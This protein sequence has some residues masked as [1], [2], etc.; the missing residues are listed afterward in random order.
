MRIKKQV[1]AKWRE[2]LIFHKGGVGRRTYIPEPVN[3]PQAELPE[4][5]IRKSELNLP[6]VSELELVRHVI[7]LSQMSYAVDTGTYPLGSCTMK[8]N[9]KVNER[10]A[11]F[12][13]FLLMHPDAPESIQ[14]GSLE[15][16]YRLQEALKKITGFSNFSVQPAGGAQGEYTGALMMTAYFTEKQDFGRKKILIPDSA[17]GTNPATATMA[18]FQAVQIP[19]NEQGTVDINALRETLDASVAGIMLT[20]PNTLGIFETEILEINRMIHSVGALSYMDGA[21]FNGIMG[22]AKP[23]EMGF[24]IMHLNLHK[25]FTGP[26]GGG[27]PGSGPVGVIPMLEKFLPTPL[28]NYDEKKDEYFWDTTHLETSIG[29]VHGY[30]GNFGINL[31]A[32]AYIYRNGGEGLRAVCLSAVLNA[33]YL[34]HKIKSVK[35]LNVPKLQ[36]LQPCK[37]E[38]V[39]SAKTLVKDT[40]ISALDI[41]KAML[42]YGIHSPTIYFPLIIKEAL[43]IEPTESETYQELNRL[44]KIIKQICEDAYIDSS[45][46]LKLPS[47]TSSGRIDEASLAKNPILSA[48]MRMKKKIH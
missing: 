2:D 23:A 10:I 18:G 46:F 5:W 3:L 41:A 24:D 35:G 26:H 43:M 16:T 21:N 33:N 15:I 8:Y 31:R 1:Q 6:E 36:E 13:E 40:T 47:N 25:T 11:R 28:A 37:H 34:L 42:D 17:H 27:G 29:K 9:P 32:L 45:K 39:A 20:N 38:F 30:N 22:I 48:K 19:S 14:Q 44:Y 12:E 4:A 7:R